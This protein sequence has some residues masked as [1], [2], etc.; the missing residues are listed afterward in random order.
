L[1]LLF[2][3]VP[4]VPVWNK[5]KTNCISTYGG[6]KAEILEM[7]VSLSARYW[8][9]SEKKNESPYY[10]QSSVKGLTRR[11]KI[12]I[13]RPIRCFWEQRSDK[14]ETQTKHYRGHLT[15]QCVILHQSQQVSSA[16]PL[17][18]KHNMT[19]VTSDKLSPCVTDW[20]CRVGSFFGCRC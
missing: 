19:P 6:V 2:E 16:S 17:Q 7:I 4:S 14:T 1:S 11:R 13:S 10:A 18:H 5:M 20:L 3:Y 12:M 15:C 8:L 9:S